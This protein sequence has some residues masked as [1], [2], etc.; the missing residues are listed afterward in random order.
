MEN[1]KD[2]Q[3]RQGNISLILDSYDDIFSDFDPRQYSEKALSDDF[4]SECKRA[5]KDKEVGVELRLLVP[6]HK[7]KFDDENKIRK[8]LKNHFN[9]HF[10]E[11]EKEMRSVK[12]EGLMWF[13]LGVVVMVAATFFY[14][15]DEFIF[16]LLFIMAEPASW[17]LFWEGLNLIIFESKKIS[18]NL[19]FYRKMNECHINFHPY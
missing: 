1:K 16:T 18:P 15:R 11:K 14:K 13:F 12:R 3:M 17:F 2:A 7:R 19:E 6:K 8:R 10:K 5:A 9:K 4:L